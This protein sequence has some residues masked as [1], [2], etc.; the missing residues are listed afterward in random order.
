MRP[1]AF[2][3]IDLTLVN[4]NGAGRAAMRRAFEG[5]GFDGSLVMQVPI[6]GRTDRAIFLDVLERCGVPAKEL[7]AVLGE[8]T[9]RYLALLPEELASRRG[10]VL[11][12]AREILE[13]LVERGWAL[14]L[15]TGNFQR[16]AEQKLLFY[17]LRDP[18]AFGGFGDHGTARVQVIAQALAAAEEHLGAP[19]VRERAWVIGDTPLDIEGARAAGLRA[20]GVATGNYSAEALRQAGADA[21]VETLAPTADVL[22]IL[23]G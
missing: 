3:D 13:V 7:D 14:G 4:T 5:L 12:G 9:E 17:G 19:L 16:G 10:V 2:F 22:A 11:P 8:V 23:D 1:V 20:L 21:V 6:D 18:F 15:A